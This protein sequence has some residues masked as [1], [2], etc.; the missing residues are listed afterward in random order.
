[1][2]KPNITNSFKKFSFKANPIP[3][4]T[5]SP[6]LPAKI[7]VILLKQRSKSV[8]H[9]Q[10]SDKKETPT[11]FHS[12]PVPLSTFFRPVS[13]D[14][15]LRKQRRFQRALTLLATS[16]Q[17]GHMAEHSVRWRVQQKL[18]HVPRCYQRQDQ[19]ERV[20]SKS[21][22]DFRRM[23]HEF[24]NKLQEMKMFR[25]PT[26]VEPFHFHLDYPKHYCNVGFHYCY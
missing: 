11:K 17:P 2:N 19:T 18:R 21:V 4:T 5:Y 3:K 6:D 15:N 1:M 16:S 8:A 25:P 14:E 23:H 22:P 10:D 12:N 13:S 9:L 26:L 20:R 7:G 24:E